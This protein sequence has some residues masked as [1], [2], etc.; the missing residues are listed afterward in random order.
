MTG[1]SFFFFFFFFFPVRMCYYPVLEGK[2][3]MGYMPTAHA[4][5]DVRFLSGV[6]YTGKIYAEYKNLHTLLILQVATIPAL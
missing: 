4:F 6:H 2:R 1:Q 3:S 5:Q